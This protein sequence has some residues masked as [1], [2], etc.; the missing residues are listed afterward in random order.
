MKT[1]VLAAGSL[2]FYSATLQA[3]K[4]TDYAG[5]DNQIKTEN[6]ESV[7]STDKGRK[8]ERAVSYQTNQQFMR[9]FPDAENIRW[10]PGR[11]FE[12]ATF[13]NGHIEMTAYYD[14]DSQLIGTTTEKK[15]SDIPTKSQE[16][17]S[18]H[19]KG[20]SPETVLLFDDNE[21]NSTDM[22]LYDTVFEDADNYFVALKNDS[23]GIIILK[24][25]MEGGVSFF[26]KL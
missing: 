18:K 15:F 23:Q 14:V 26:K 20:Y 22:M 3:Q 8:E 2:L 16:Y 10:N 13:T 19:Y 21:D 25:N 6:A 5:N 24:V 12:E 11:P 7:V 9:D 1:I 17:I 4:E